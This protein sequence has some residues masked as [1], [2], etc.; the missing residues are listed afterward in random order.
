MH[1]LL[2]KLEFKRV[3]GLNDELKIHYVLTSLILMKI[4]I[5]CAFLWSFKILI[6]FFNN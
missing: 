6:D 3:V 1:Q 4:D 5:F 2:V